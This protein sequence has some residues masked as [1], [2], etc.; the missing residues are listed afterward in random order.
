MT[1]RALREDVENQA[2]AIEY[3]PLDQLF[4]IALLTGAERMIDENHV[5]ILGQGDRT[6]FLGLAA[7]NEEA[8]IGPVA[9]AAHSRHRHSAR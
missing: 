5:G 1:T 2:T 6:D 9:P 8:W 3:P 7:A 4:Q